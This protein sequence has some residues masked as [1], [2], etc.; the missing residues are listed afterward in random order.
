[1]GHG[2]SSLARIALAVSLL[3]SALATHHLAFPGGT[4]AC[5]CVAPDPGAPVFTGEELAV[6]VGTAGMPQPDGTHAFVVERW[7]KGGPAPVVRVASE[8]V[9]FADGSTAID[10]CGLHFE[11]GDRLLLTASVDQQGRYG[12]GLCMPHAVVESPEG[13]R[14]LAAAE[15]TFGEGNVPGAPSA[16]DDMPDDPDLTGFAI[17]MVGILVL[18]VVI[19]ML[20]A[21]RRRR[22][23]ELLP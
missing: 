20:A 10:T 14:L 7:F 19:A 17:G 23:E 11:V 13:Q 8:R 22:E 21:A 16:P 15:A 12:P 5:S 3:S 1:V 6:F 18:I 9:V 4:L 2:L